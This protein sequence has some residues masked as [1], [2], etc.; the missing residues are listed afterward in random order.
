MWSRSGLARWPLAWA[1]W[2]APVWI[3]CQTAV[4][5]NSKMPFG[6]HDGGSVVGQ[7]IT[8]GWRLLWLRLSV[9]AGLAILGCLF[10]TVDIPVASWFQKHRLSGDLAR[11]FDFSEVFAHGLG[12]AAVLAVAISLDPF[13]RQAGRVPAARQAITRLVLAAFAGGL[14]VD[15][16]KGVVTRV[17]PRAADLTAVGSALG[18]F[19]HGAAASDLA[20]GGLIGKSADLMSFPSGHA[21]VAAGLATALTWRYPHGLAI[22]ATLAASAAAQRVVSS[23]HYPSDVAFGAAI[24]V[25][26]AAVCLAGS[27][28]T[29]PRL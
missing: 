14:L 5:T 2:W 13:L 21:A 16:I 28:S 23:A 8:E 1:V 24:G 12:A 29:V 27:K 19:G 15:L 4:M 3:L 17:R 11:L 25:A 20:G 26:A 18:T 7:A 9:A 10:F 22:F 6:Q